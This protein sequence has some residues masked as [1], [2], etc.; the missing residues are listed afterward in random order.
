MGIYGHRHQDTKRLKPLK[1]EELSDRTPAL[2][3][4]LPPGLDHY[5]FKKRYKS[6]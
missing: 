6:S 4:R 2:D 1:T 5:F 3:S